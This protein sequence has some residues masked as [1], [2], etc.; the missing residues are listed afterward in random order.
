MDSSVGYDDILGRNRVRHK[1][2]HQTCR[3]RR[4]WGNGSPVLPD[5]TVPSRSRL[6][7]DRQG[8]CDPGDS[9]GIAEPGGHHERLHKIT[10]VHEHPGFTV[11]I[12]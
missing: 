12:D 1:V 2:R 10:V 8:L 5:G 4:V 7:C 11:D 9:S 6:L 3:E